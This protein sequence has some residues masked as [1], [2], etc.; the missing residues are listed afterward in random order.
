MTVTNRK[1]S[2]S[3]TG[4]Y[5]EGAVAGSSGDA[6]RDPRHRF[7]AFGEERASEYL[8]RR[9][10]EILARNVR[11]AYGEI[12]IIARDGETVVFVEVKSRRGRQGG[13]ALEAVDARKRKRLSRLALA[14]LARAGWLDR[15]A[16]FDVIA[17]ASDG[18][19]T[20]VANA[21]DCGPT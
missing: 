14:F 20:H 18:A 4:R 19:C 6:P 7:G 12:D 21:F 5:P 10:F 9:G 15:P 1:Q 8:R 17:V 13:T 2:R 3:G 11:T 16:R